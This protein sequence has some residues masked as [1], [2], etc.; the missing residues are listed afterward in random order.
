MG[1]VV[2]AVLGGYVVLF[3]VVF[4][5][6]TVAWLALGTSGAFA[7]SSWEPSGTWLAINIVVGLTAALLG[8]FTCASIARGDRR[9]T[10]GL[11]GLIIVFG[12]LFAIPV[13]RG[14]RV[15]RGARTDVLTMT[16]AMQNIRMP[17]WIALLNPVLGAAGVVLGA[18]M[19][20]RGSEV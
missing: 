10:R 13:I 14:S 17:V 15:E 11:V 3:L 16:E 4:V 6:S 5:A 8:G 1:R 20:R 12:L 19:R 2:G 18:G 7:P 9:A